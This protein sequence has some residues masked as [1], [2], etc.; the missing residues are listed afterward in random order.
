MPPKNAHNVPQ[1]VEIAVGESVSVSK[2]TPLVSD[3]SFG[4]A[5]EYLRKIECI[6]DIEKSDLSEMEVI[7]HAKAL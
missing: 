4:E 6:S 7:R 2:K 1:G 5:I 3:M